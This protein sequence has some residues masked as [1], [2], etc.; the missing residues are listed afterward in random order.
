MTD[1]QSKILELMRD[2]QCRDIGEAEGKAVYYLND[3]E[4][5]L[6]SYKRLETETGKSRPRLQVEMKE[7]RDMG[8]VEL[9]V[10]VDYEFYAPCGSGWILT[11]KGVEHLNSQI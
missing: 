4:T 6:M 2:M 10:A 5:P 7:L 11:A 1:T 8:M 9:T 3:D